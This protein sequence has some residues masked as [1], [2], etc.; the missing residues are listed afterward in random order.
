MAVRGQPYGKPAKGLERMR[1]LLEGAMRYGYDIR[2]VY[3]GQVYEG[4]VRPS[5]HNPLS[6]F[7]L[8]DSRAVEYQLAPWREAYDPEREG[9]MELFIDL[10]VL[11]EVRSSGGDPYDD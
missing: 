10:E 2:V 1:Q 11:T 6:R 4:Q 9:W 3:R 5:Q 8:R 7:Q